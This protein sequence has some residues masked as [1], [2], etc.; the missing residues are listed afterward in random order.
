MKSKPLFWLRCCIICWTVCKMKNSNPSEVPGQWGQTKRQV[1]WFLIFVFVFFL[2][3]SSRKFVIWVRVKSELLDSSP[4]SCKR[5]MFCCEPSYIYRHNGYNEIL[6]CFHFF[7]LQCCS[8]ENIQIFAIVQPLCVF[9]D[10]QKM[11]HSE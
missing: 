1:A 5:A 11:I 8:H 6:K 7:S 3:V 2:A 9:F 4:C 10:F